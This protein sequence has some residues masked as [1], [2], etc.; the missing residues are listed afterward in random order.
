MG[1][2]VRVRVR[3][4]L[5][6]SVSAPVSSSRVKSCSDWTRTTSFSCVGAGCR[7][8]GAGCRVQGAGPPSPPPA[9]GVRELG[10][11]GFTRSRKVRL[12]RDGG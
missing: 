3:V 9:T 2:G 7:V 5:P 6:A 12:L 1:V 4:A 8:Q 11:R 10:L